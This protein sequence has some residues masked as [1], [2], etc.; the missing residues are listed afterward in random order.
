[1]NAK[2]RYTANA[3]S[4]KMVTIFFT[5]IRILTEKRLMPYLYEGAALFI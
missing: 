2:T 5:F 4:S 3:T 1:V